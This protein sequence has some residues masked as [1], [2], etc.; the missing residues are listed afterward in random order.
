PPH[1]P[2]VR[3]RPG[4]DRQR[5]RERRP[6]GRRRRHL[7]PDQLPLRGRASSGLIFQ[8]AMSFANRGSERRA[9]KLGSIESQ[10]FVR[11]GTGVSLGY[12][13][14]SDGTGNLSA[15]GDTKT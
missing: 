13:V 11:Y 1:Q 5:G 9:S 3:G 4:S 12:N 7:L 14:S 15:T 10:P 2:P 6:E 8:R